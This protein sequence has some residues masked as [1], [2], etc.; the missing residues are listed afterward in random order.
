MESALVVE[1]NER[2]FRSGACNG[3]ECLRMVFEEDGA[4]GGDA[5]TRGQEG[6]AEDAEDPGLEVGVGL[7]GVEGAQGLE[8]SLLHKVFGLGLIAGE[9]VSVVVEGG[10]E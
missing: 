7:K 6:V 5:G 8:E 10:K 2:V 4:G 9:P 3:I 1:A